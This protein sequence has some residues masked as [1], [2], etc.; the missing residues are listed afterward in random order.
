MTILVIIG[1]ILILIL[2]IWAGLLIGLAIE[3]LDDVPGDDGFYKTG[4][5]RK[6]GS[7]FWHAV[8]L[9]TPNRPTCKPLSYYT[10][11]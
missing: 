4:S 1:I 2:V 7:R 9:S 11:K 10:K 3:Y 5:L 6:G 8:A